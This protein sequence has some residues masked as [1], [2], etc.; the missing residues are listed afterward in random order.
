VRVDHR[1]SDQVA[2]ESPPKSR[3][4]TRHKEESR[5]SEWLLRPGFE[6]EHENLVGEFGWRKPNRHST[7]TSASIP[8][9]IAMVMMVTMSQPMSNDI[10]INQMTVKRKWIKDGLG[11]F[12]C[13]RESMK[14]THPNSP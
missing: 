5:S 11:K 4:R 13:I 10:G 9:L 14:R 1:K 2:R 3:Y 12:L 7:K 8:D 6:H